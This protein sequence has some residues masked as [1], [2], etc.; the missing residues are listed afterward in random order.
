MIHKIVLQDELFTSGS[1]K[2]KITTPYECNVG[3]LRMAN[4]G[5]GGAPQR[6][7]WRMSQVVQPRP[8]HN[9]VLTPLSTHGGQ[10]A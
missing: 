3:L 10:M 8:N 4:L 2:K 7:I 5:G 6:S 1:I 9:C